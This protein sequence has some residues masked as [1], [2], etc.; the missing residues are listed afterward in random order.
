MA[1]ALDDP[2]FL[3]A[4]RIEGDLEIEIS[5]LSPLRAIASEDRF[6]I[7]RHGAHLRV[8]ACRGLLLPQVGRHRDWTTCDFLNALAR[9]AGL[10]PEAWR[11]PRAHLSVF[12]AQVFS[13]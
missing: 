2:R 5:V 6:Q 8:G 7:G 12:E 11:N 4:A 9:K 13:R 3:P 1:A 10:A